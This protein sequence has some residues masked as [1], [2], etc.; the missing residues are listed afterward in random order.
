MGL[1]LVNTRN[2]AIDLL[3]Q[4]LGAGIGS[5]AMTSLYLFI[6]AFSLF[7]KQGFEEGNFM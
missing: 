7:S 2:F 1:M 3:A 4:F 5:L 6:L